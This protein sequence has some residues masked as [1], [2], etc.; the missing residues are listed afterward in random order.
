M[1][2]FFSLFSLLQL[3]GKH[4]TEF[5]LAGLW[6]YLNIN[7][8]ASQYM[9]PVRVCAMYSVEAHH[10]GTAVLYA[11]VGWVQNKDKV[12]SCSIYEQF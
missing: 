6:K 9:G 2:F 4:I 10:R 7:N 8:N 5:L 1:L 3:L 11:W 12:S